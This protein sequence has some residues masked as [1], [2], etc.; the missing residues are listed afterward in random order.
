ML[1][2]RR[3]RGFT[4]IELLVVIAIIAILAA[5]LFPV[6]ARARENARA[7]SCL[8]NVKQMGLSIEMYK[9]DYDGKYPA[10]RWKGGTGHWYDWY[11]APYIKNKQVQICPDHTDWTIGY[12][13][14]IAFG[15][16]IGSGTN[17][18]TTLSFCGVNIPAYGGVSDAIIN[19]PSQSVVLLDAS[20]D[21]YHFTIDSGYSDGTAKGVLD[22]FFSQNATDASLT[23]SYNH[24]EAGV[25]N[26]GVNALYADG[27]AKWRKLDFYFNH[28]IY[29]PVQ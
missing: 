10:A 20:L 15:Y 4:L 5:I 27:H 29:C 7:S 13:Y 22:A 9:Q 16:D 11:L 26:G 18:S 19:N 21:Y 25:H 3:F 12:S 17:P 6:F 23:A 2:K 8:S 28:T 24:P 1:Q 14:N